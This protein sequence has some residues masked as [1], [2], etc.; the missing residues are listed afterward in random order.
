MTEDAAVTL[1]GGRRRMGSADDGSRRYMDV[2]SDDEN[3]VDNI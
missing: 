2:S 3:V 1:D